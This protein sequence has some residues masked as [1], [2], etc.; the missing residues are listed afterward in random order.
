MSDRQ[1]D[2]ALSHDVIGAAIEVH[3]FLGP[4]LFESIYE[5]CLEHELELRGHRISRQETLRVE[6]KGR[7]FERPFRSDLIVNDE[8]LLELKSIQELSTLHSSQV[9]SY[10]RILKLPRGIL[11]NFNVSRLVDGVRRLEFNS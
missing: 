3:R 1:F 4:G 5:D 6:Y 2:D 10:L 11:I 9:L 7:L 8:L